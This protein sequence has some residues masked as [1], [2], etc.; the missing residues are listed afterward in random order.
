MRFII[1]YTK[2]KAA[3]EGQFCFAPSGELARKSHMVGFDFRHN[4]S[5]EKEH[6]DHV[7]LDRKLAQCQETYLHVIGKQIVST[8]LYIIIPGLVILQLT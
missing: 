8:N 1:D 3:S 6:F 5:C 7:T 4:V 2:V